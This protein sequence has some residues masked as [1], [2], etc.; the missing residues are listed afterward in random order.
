[1]DAKEWR[2][3]AD[4]TLKFVS[5][6]GEDVGEDV[7]SMADEGLLLVLALHIGRAMGRIAKLE[8]ELADLRA[9]DEPMIAALHEGQDKLRA[10][11][12][13]MESAWAKADGALTD[14]V[15]ERNN[16]WDL[17]QR[18]LYPSSGAGE[19]A[20]TLQQLCLDTVAALPEDM[21]KTEP[22]RYELIYAMLEAVKKLGEP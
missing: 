12:A 18:W 20:E 8:G 19:T 2:V 6:G 17:L 16:A 10:R 3:W 22:T 14:T 1:M 4:Q 15:E 9:H 13:E 11:L 21:R 5:I 7:A